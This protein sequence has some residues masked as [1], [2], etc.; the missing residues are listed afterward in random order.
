[1]TASTVQLIRDVRVATR[2]DI[3]MA[4][5]GWKRNLGEPVARPVATN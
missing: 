5:N 1:M 2:H 4:R 3:I